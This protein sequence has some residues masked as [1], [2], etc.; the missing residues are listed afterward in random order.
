[1]LKNKKNV[2]EKSF[3]ENISKKTVS[4]TYFSEKQRSSRIHIIGFLTFFFVNNFFLT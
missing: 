1:M 2:E 4:V 3:F